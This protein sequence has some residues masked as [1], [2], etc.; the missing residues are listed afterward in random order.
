VPS[1]QPISTNLG[2]F[3]VC[4]FDTNNLFGSSAG[5][6]TEFQ[7]QYQVET[8]PGVGATT[9]IEMIETLIE[10][11]LN[12]A[13]LPVLFSRCAITTRRLTVSSGASGNPPDKI[14]IGATCVGAQEGNGCFVV[15]GRATIY[16]TDG[17]DPTLDIEEAQNAIRE[18]LENGT[19]DNLDS[20]LVRVTFS[21]QTGDQ[22]DNMA[23][24]NNTRTTH[25]PS[26]L[27]TF[28]SALIGICILAAIGGTCC[29]FYRRRSAFLNKSVHG[30]RYAYPTNQAVEH[31][32]RPFNST[33]SH[34]LEYAGPEPP[35]YFDEEYNYIT[36]AHDLGHDIIVVDQPSSGAHAHVLGTGGGTPVHSQD[37]IGYQQ[38]DGGSAVSTSTHNT[39][40]PGEILIFDHWVVRA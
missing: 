3:S 17:L 36:S 20:R 6:P 19:F 29:C 1:F 25:S 40:G 10:P 38:S 7:Y 16:A 22:S 11:V 2:G 14:L 23:G 39:R 31:Q 35:L 30:S 18:S 27:P 26:G 8:T 4:K 34:R 24:M 5:T 13:I 21:D 15:T 12:E 37:A 33:A 28:G 9:V 32:R